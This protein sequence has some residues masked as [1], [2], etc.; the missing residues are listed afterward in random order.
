MS[1]TLRSLFLVLLLALVG[2]GAGSDSRG[3]GSDA[4]R[5]QEI[6]RTEGVRS[7]LSK[8][9]YDLLVAS[10]RAVEA[11][12]KGVDET[13]RGAVR[14]AMDKAFRRARDDCQQY[15]SAGPVLRSLAASCA[16]GVEGIESYIDLALSRGESAQCDDADACAAHLERLAELFDA[17]AQSILQ[18]RRAFR[19]S[20][21]GPRCRDT[22][23]G[24]RQLGT[25]FAA[26]AATFRGFADA[27]SQDEIDRRADVA[28]RRMERAL[29]RAARLRPTACKDD[30]G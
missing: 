19:D 23:I 17:T 5:W 25:A 9:E 10:D 12:W 2:C 11:I 7:P 18:P 1:P 26:M 16:S 14:A 20:P 27:P 28:D 8:R 24:P 22:L 3:L 30:V 21:L 13:D 6:A 29:A 15:R 4:Q